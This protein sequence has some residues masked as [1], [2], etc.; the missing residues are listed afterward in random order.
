MYRFMIEDLI[1]SFPY[2]FV[3][4]EQ[5]QYMLELKR[6]L[7]SEVMPYFFLLRLPLG[8]CHIG[9]AYWNRKDR[10]SPG[11]DPFVHPDEETE[12]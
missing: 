5:Y 1:V 12:L 8:P 7:D 9:D 2:Q 10:V 4:P 6:T 3:Y 11:I